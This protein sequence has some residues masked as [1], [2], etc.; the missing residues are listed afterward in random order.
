MKQHIQ[1]LQRFR[2]WLRGEDVIELPDQREVIAAIDQLIDDVNQL[3]RD[4]AD[5]KNE[6]DLRSKEA[7]EWQHKYNMLV[8]ECQAAKTQIYTF[9]HGNN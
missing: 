4:R 9:V 5:C 6:T 8:I 2:S 1:T 7:A 3:D